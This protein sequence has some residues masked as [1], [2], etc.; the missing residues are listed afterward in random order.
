MSVVYHTPM[1]KTK[2]K[3]LAIP[4]DNPVMK[5]S[6][7]NLGE[8]VTHTTKN[9][10]GMSITKSYMVVGF[11][12]VTKSSK[13]LTGTL[14]ESIIEGR[15]EGDRIKLYVAGYGY[16]TRPDNKNL[17]IVQEVK[18]A[19]YSNGWEIRLSAGFSCV[20]NGRGFQSFSVEQCASKVFLKYTRRVQRTAH[21]KLQEAGLGIQCVALEK[22]CVDATDPSTAEFGY[23]TKECA[24][25][26]GEPI[27]I[28]AETDSDIAIEHVTDGFETIMCVGVSTGKAYRISLNHILL[29]SYGFA[30]KSIRSEMVQSN[31]A[32]FKA[33]ALSSL[34][35]WERKHGME[36][37]ATNE[38]N[39]KLNMD[40][41]NLAALLT[42]DDAQEAIA[43][44]VDYAAILEEE[45]ALQED[46]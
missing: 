35:G 44:I 39:N 7:M 18:D 40:W 43:A 31:I 14:T 3:L 15:S 36:D 4:A 11:A 20:I 34:N 12:D 41:K 30:W 5:L 33:G 21:D 28:T 27:R 19:T 32:E 24:L 37:H 46:T 8:I 22:V 23:N 1:T 42:S 45:T 16:I 10:Y 25:I 6:E 17:R 9:S 13:G 2:L 26:V 29:D 38:R